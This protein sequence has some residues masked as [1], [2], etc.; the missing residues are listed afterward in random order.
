M[1]SISCFADTLAHFPLAYIV[2][3]EVPVHNTY[4]V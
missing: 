2:Y 3:Y 4:D 1:S